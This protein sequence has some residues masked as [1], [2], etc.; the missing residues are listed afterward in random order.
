MRAGD[1]TVGRSASSESA[2]SCLASMHTRSALTTGRSLGGS[3]AS[4]SFGTNRVGLVF[5]R[6]FGVVLDGDGD[7]NVSERRISRPSAEVARSRNVRLWNGAAS[8]R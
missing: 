8:F 3:N 2:P 5:P 7:P 1:G 6:D 4:H